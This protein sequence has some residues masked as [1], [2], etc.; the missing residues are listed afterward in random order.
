MSLQ[1]TGGW[2]GGNITEK[3]FSDVSLFGARTSQLHLPIPKTNERQSVCVVRLTISPTLLLEVFGLS[4]YSYRRG[5]TALL[6]PGIG[7]NA[8]AC[9]S[10]DKQKKQTPAPFLCPNQ[11]YNSKNHSRIWGDY[12]HKRKY[13][14][15]IINLRKSKKLWQIHT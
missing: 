12:R 8:K 10:R 14:E 6:I 11:S 7:G 4:W 9:A 1:P 2:A 5:L 15:K 13:H 3:T